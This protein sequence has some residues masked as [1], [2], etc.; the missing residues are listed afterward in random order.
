MVAAF[1][2][3]SKLLCEMRWEDDETFRMSLAFYLE[4]EN[5]KHIVDVGTV[6]PIVPQKSPQVMHW[7]PIREYRLL[8]VIKYVPH[9]CKNC[10][11]LFRILHCIYLAL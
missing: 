7:F 2:W 3:W 11:Y 9:D 8:H 10:F 1:D 4:S 6:S 5:V